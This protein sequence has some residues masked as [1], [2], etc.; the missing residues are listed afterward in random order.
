MLAIMSETNFN[1][2]KSK[3]ICKQFKWDFFLFNY[4]NNL[5]RTM[6]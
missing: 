4:S 6:I 3:T 1:E 5:Q 2:S